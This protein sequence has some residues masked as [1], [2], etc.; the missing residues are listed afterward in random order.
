MIATP[1]AASVPGRPWVT[2]EPIRD[3]KVL[4][5]A[6]CLE[7]GGRVTWPVPGIDVGGW[8]AGALIQDALPMLS[9][10]DRELL[11]SGNCGVCF[12]TLFGDDA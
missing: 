6:Q 5:R 12:D 7:C 1:R 4:L 2:V 10:N 8:V 11:I 3:G 9:E